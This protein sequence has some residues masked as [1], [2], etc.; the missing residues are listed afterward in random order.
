MVTAPINTGTNKMAAVLIVMLISVLAAPT[1]IWASQV[2]REVDLDGTA[3]RMIKT[4]PKEIINAPKAKRFSL[5]ARHDEDQATARY[6]EEIRVFGDRDP[7][8]VT[9]PKRT[10]M[11]AFRDKLERE[12]TLTPKDI[13]MMGLCFIGLC[14]AHYGPD[15]APVE[16]RAFTRAETKKNKSSLE[17]S[18]QFRGTYQ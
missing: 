2:L 6:A 17:M 3:A 18:Q 1:P 7:E 9:S 4:V 14:G 10:P 8:D 11:L 5:A 12:K 16:D 13:T 15:G